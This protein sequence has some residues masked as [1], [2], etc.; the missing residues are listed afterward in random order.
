M[1]PRIH[2]TIIIAAPAGGRLLLTEGRSAP[3]HLQDEV[4]IAVGPAFGP[5]NRQYRGLTAYI[6]R[7][8]IAG[9]EEE[10]NQG[11]RVIR[12]FKSSDARSSP[13]SVNRLSDPHLHRHPVERR[14]HGYPPKVVAAAL[15]PSSCSRISTAADAGN[16]PRLVIS[17]K[18]AARWRFQSPQPVPTLNDQDGTLKRLP[19]KVAILHIKEFQVRSTA[20][21]AETR[22]ALYKSR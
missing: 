18:N 6:L 19:R 3:A 21:P 8:V 2:S 12:C 5:A 9:I 1:C 22:V 20:K 17:Q 14:T 15:Q 16:P 11:A 13:F 10:V 4:I 7:E